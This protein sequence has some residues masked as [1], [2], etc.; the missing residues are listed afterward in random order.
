MLLNRIFKDGESWNVIVKDKVR[1]GTFYHLNGKLEDDVV[2]LKFKDGA[3]V[4]IVKKPKSQSR[5]EVQ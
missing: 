4:E 1:N 5:C 3:L 2:D